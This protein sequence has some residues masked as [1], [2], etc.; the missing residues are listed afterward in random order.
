MD[1]KRFSP[2]PRESITMAVWVKLDTSRGIQSI[3]DTVGGALSTHKEG[4]YHLEIDN[5]RVR[6]FHRNEKHITI[7]SIL[8]DPVLVEG[9][10]THITGT[11][12]GFKREA[13]VNRFLSIAIPLSCH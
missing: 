13:Q 8:S 12:N 6:W 10:W 9:N 1:G 11:Y 2:K 4:Q 7:F 5:A 3:F